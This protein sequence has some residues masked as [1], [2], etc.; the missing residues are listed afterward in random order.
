MQRL[1]PKLPR[2]PRVRL[3]KKAE[4][5][6]ELHQIGEPWATQSNDDGIAYTEFTS[7]VPLG[8]RTVLRTSLLDGEGKPLL[9][10]DREMPWEIRNYDATVSGTMGFSGTIE[11]RDGGKHIH[12]IDHAGGGTIEYTWDGT[13]TRMQMSLEGMSIDWVYQNEFVCPIAAI[14]GYNVNHNP[15]VFISD[16]QQYDIMRWLNKE[17][18]VEF[19]GISF[20]ETYYLGHECKTMREVTPEASGTMVMYQNLVLRLL[21]TEGDM[22]VTS[23]KIYDEIENPIT[24]TRH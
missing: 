17:H 18:G 20:G 10:M 3:R 15:G 23:L 4:S 9:D 13:N 8:Y 12:E 6:S 1:L 7:P 22:N 5:N 16:M 11:Y 24:I 21:S 2:M 19:P 14:M